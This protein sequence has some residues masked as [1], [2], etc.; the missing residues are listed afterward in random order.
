MGAI[1]LAAGRG[2]R[3]NGLAAPFM[4]PT[5]LVNGQPII[6][7]QIQNAL[8]VTQ[9]ITLVLAPENARAMLDLIHHALPKLEWDYVQVV[10]QPFN[11]GVVD[12]LKRGLML[13]NRDVIVLMGDNVVPPMTVR[14]MWD[15]FV[16]EG[17]RPDLM[18]C[19]RRMPWDDAQRFTYK[20]SETWW[21]KEQ[22]Q[23]VVYDSKDGTEVWVGPLIIAS[24]DEFYAALGDGDSVG[25]VFNAFNQVRTWEG[26]CS[27]IGVPE[28]LDTEREKFIPRTKEESDALWRLYPESMGR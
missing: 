7:Q 18:V 8:E 20:T 28:A 5:L 26:Q 24:S 27:D 1:I 22:P 14:H 6:V 3:L 11:G 9:M 19:T 2:E 21:E 17:A 10:V 12:A 13:Y 25:Q 23:G 16:G 4:K 15:D